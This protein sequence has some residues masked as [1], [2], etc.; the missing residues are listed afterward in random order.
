MSSRRDSIVGAIVT[1]LGA[2]GKP[3]GLTVH[4]HRTLPIGEDILPAQVVYCESEEAKVGPGRGVSDNSY[5][6]KAKRT[7]TVVIESRVNAGSSTPDQ[8]L[9]PLLSWCVQQVSADVTQGGYAFDTQEQ[10]TIWNA[11]ETDAV[12]GAAQTRFVIEYVTDAAD[13]N[14]LT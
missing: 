11:A 6:R 5:A 10:S 7:L 8:A 2:V 1:A 9:D 12:L 14:S 3:S 13:P 4:R